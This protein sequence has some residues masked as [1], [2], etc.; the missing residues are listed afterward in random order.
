ME[1]ELEP[2][3]LEPASRGKMSG[4]G[5]AYEPGGGSWRVLPPAPIT[6]RA[7]TVGVWTGREVIIW[8]EGGRGPADGAAY[9]P[10][11]ESWRTLPRGGPVDEVGG[12]VWTGREMVVWGFGG[13][14]A[15][16]PH[17]NRW[18]VLPRAPFSPWF[19][20]TAVW[21]GTDLLFVGGSDEPGRVPSGAAYDAAGD[22]WRTLTAA[23][24]PVDISDATATWTGRLLVVARGP[25]R[26]QVYDPADDS[27]DVMPGLSEGPRVGSVAV[28]TGDEMVFWGGYGV[29]GTAAVLEEGVA[30]RP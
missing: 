19:T 22:R 1:V 11:R 18:R 24:D 8:G 6:P 15:F 25:S 26:V 13:F 28:W 3:A 5:A 12:G 27:W 29:L 20:N 9:D 4:E 2:V 14:A 7:G 23:P 10:A 30:W 17:T 21:T 16:N